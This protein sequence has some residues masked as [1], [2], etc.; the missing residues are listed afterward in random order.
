M[1]R[2]SN[3]SGDGT[4]GQ[5]A[6]ATP[7]LLHALQALALV[8]RLHHVAREPSTLAHQLGKAPHAPLAIDDLLLVAKQLG[9]RA[10]RTAVSHERLLL[11]PLPALALMKDG[12]IAVLAQCD[13]QRVL[14]QR[15]TNGAEP[16]PIIEPLPTFIDAWAGDLILITSRASLAGELAKFDFS[17]FVPSLVKHRRLIGEVLAVSAFLQLFALVSPLFF[18]VVMDKV[19]V[20]PRHEVP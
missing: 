9:L 19:L 15:F 4:H 13:R 14:L 12:S 2:L 1:S 5:P 6:T 10:K 11:T 8:A 7:T 17:W 18:Q 3:S 16:R 20:Q